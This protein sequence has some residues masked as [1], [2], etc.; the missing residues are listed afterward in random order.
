MSRAWSVKELEAIILDYL[1]MLQKELRGMK[2]SKTE[3]RKKVM[4]KLDN[5][6]DGSIEYKHQNISFVMIKHNYPYIQ[7]YK[8][9]SNIQKILEDKVLELVER[10][11]IQ[12]MESEYADIDPRAG[13]GELLTEGQRTTITVNRYERNPEARDK[14]IAYHGY[15]CQ[16][17][18]FSFENKYGEYG[19]FF[20]EVHHIKPISEMDES[21]N[22]DPINDLIP[23]C[24]NCHSIVHR[25]RKETMDIE[26]MRK[27]VDENG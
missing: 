12:R 6:T 22:V 18:G 5:R 19:K 21:Y 15:D 20:I 26:E 17:C 1:S 4:R 3:H 7:G 11:D 14:C 23:I 8:P 16:I 25:K 24:S 9:K 2:Y 10:E 13:E 27:I